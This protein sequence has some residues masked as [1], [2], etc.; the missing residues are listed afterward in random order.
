MKRRVFNF[1]AGVSLVL[2]VA[3]VVLWV[4][5]YYLADSF[6]LS[7]LN[8]LST[9]R[10]QLLLLVAEP[11]CNFSVRPGYRRAALSDPSDTWNLRRFADQ[12]WNVL[13]AHGEQIPGLHIVVV[14]F[15]AL[16]VIA[17]APLVLVLARSTL[18]RRRLAGHRCGTCGYDLR[19]TPARC[20]ECGAM[21][22]A[23][24]T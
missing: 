14:Q 18:R 11:N 3:T 8:A 9:D 13:I 20:P 6:G 12:T 24:A 23:T 15:W 10:G 16:A 21:P 2:C 1:A 7:Q 22:S 5:S 4:R 17:A 19:A